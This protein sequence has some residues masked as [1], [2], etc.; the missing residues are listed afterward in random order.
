MIELSYA[1]A[2]AGKA[3]FEWTYNQLDPRAYHSALGNFAY[4]I[5]ERAAPVFRRLFDALRRC[6]QLDTITAVDL[7]CSYGINATLLKHDLSMADLRA[8]YASF[9]AEASP[10][11][12]LALDQKVFSPDKARGDLKVLGLDRAQFATAYAYWAGTLDGAIA[13][14]LEEDDPSEQA[15]RTLCDC[16]AI[17]STGTVGYI[18]MPSFDRIIKATAHKAQPWIASF[19]LRMFDYAP[20][21][22]R[23]AAQGYVTETL[24]GVYFAQRRFVGRREQAHVETILRQR[25]LDPAG[26]ESEGSYVAECF[27]SRPKD[28]VATAPLKQLLP[29]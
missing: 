19:V 8:H 27:V 29:I 1:D 28:E 6:R 9:D 21:A 4:D 5:P 25:G 12:V 22:D 11:E 13:E 2:N 16:D 17:I 20:I 3:N 14:N 15:A 26:L 18:G 10:R 24:T 7:G 23:L